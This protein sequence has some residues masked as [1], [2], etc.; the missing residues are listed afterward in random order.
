MGWKTL[1]L[2]EVNFMSGVLSTV[3][4]LIAA[5]ARFN[6]DAALFGRILPSGSTE[7][8]ISEVAFRILPADI[9]GLPWRDRI[10]P[11]R[12]GLRLL[13]GQIVAWDLLGE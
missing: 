3:V 6:N 7:L 9:A 2:A 11:Q 12:R 8:L 1:D 10:A 4:K 5:Q 13:A